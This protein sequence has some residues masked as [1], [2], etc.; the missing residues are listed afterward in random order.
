VALTPE[1]LDVRIVDQRTGRSTIQEAFPGT[2]MDLRTAVL[3]AV[4]LLRWHLRFTPAS[5]A[6]AA[7]TP[8][9]PVEIEP[10]PP[11][12]LAQSNTRVGLTSLAS[13]SPGGSGLGIG[14]Q[15]DVLRQWG[16]FGAR[17]LA[18]TVFVPNRI[19]VPEGSL[20]ISASWGG[21]AGVLI[22]GGQ[23]T[24]TLEIGAGA[25]I[26]VSALHGT[27]NTGNVGQDDRVITFS[28]FGELRLRRRVT[29]KFGVNV[30]SAV[31][32]P[33]E[34]SHLRVLDRE[35]GRYGQVVVAFGIG[36]ELALF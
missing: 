14:G 28:P 6:P 35:V 30:G 16:R 33:Y 18:G 3:H 7:A 4:E 2:S 17:V 13:Y 9:T 25:S 8:T 5:E 19:S 27:A 32:V 22:L 10:A 21:L 20:E 12:S 24:T 26:F 34:S 11:V 31:L 23:R 15:I 1:S 29:R 36:A